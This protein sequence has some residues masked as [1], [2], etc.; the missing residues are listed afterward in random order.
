MCKKKNKKQI[1]EKTL[2]NKSKCA[3]SKIDKG[4][5]RKTQ[6]KIQKYRKLKK[7]MYV[8]SIF[9]IQQ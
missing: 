4:K 8:C 3:K 7:I 2:C 9:N 6:K 5:N 1:E